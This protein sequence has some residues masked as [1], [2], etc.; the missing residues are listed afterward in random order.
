[1]CVSVCVHRDDTFG[2]GSSTKAIDRRWSNQGQGVSFFVCWFLWKVF[3]FSLLDLC[4][5][6]VTDEWQ[7]TDF[8]SRT[9]K[10]ETSCSLVHYM[11]TSQ[12]WASV[13]G[14]TRAQAGF[15]HFFIWKKCRLLKEFWF[16]S[17]FKFNLYVRR[18]CKCT[19]PFTILIFPNKNSFES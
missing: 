4:V 2:I 8:T 15:Q 12:I 5:S 9:G 17:I 18:K 3:W 1:M 13:V 11:T 19:K 16:M 7:L 10:S 14:M 6:V